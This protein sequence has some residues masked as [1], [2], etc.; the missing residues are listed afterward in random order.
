MKT[1]V[2]AVCAFIAVATFK[3]TPVFALEPLEIYREKSPSV[4]LIYAK[5]SQR[6]S[7]GGSGFFIGP[8]G[9]ILTNAHVVTDKNNRPLT[10]I[11]VYL[12]PDRV[13]GDLKHDLTRRYTAHIVKYIRSIDIAVLKI[14]GYSG[15]ERPLRLTDSE[16]TEIG[17]RVVAIGHPEQGGLW[18]LTTGTISSR[19]MNIGGVSGKHMFQTEASINHGNSGG[20]LIDS[21]GFVVGMNTSTS[22][23]SSDGTAI[24]GVN[25][26]LQANVL[27]NWLNREGF[28]IDTARAPKAK[29]RKKEAAKKEPEKSA[30]KPPPKVKEIKPV[31]TAETKTEAKPEKEGKIITPEKPYDWQSLE[32]TVAEMEDM[33]EDMKGKIRGKF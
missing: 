2:L 29:P 13:T 23:I 11:S 4:V 12:K 3:I 30:P 6:M 31:K 18:T 7:K 24:V 14:D 16:K 8:D 21:D 19:K 26:A 9:L 20:P 28:G 25:F 10:K 15:S 32:A 22:R 5:V 27:S 17:Q 1:I 33:M